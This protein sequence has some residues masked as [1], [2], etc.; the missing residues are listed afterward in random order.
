MCECGCTMNDMKYTLPGPG[1]AFYIVTLS[2]ACEGCDA[3]S[4]ITIELIEPSN[5]LFANYKRGEFIDGPLTLE[6]WPDSKG[7]AIVAGL[8]KHEFVKAVSENLV[9]IDSKEMGEDGTIDKDG[10]DVIA[11]EMYEDSQVKP[12]VAKAQVG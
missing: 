11:E 6:Q 2:G 4:G 12:F 1:K 3:P 10:A 7:V 5:T 9:G 8:R